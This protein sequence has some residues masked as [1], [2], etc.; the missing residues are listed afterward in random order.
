M[1]I[2]YIPSGY[3]R[4]YLYFDDAIINELV[5]LKHK[6]KI[7]NIT[8]NIESLP[9]IVLTFKPDLVLTM[10][11][12]NMP[13]ALLTSIKQMRIPSAIW[14]TE[15]PYYTDKTLKFIHNYDFIFT[16]ESSSVHLYEEAGHNKVYYLPLGTNPSIYTSLNFNQYKYDISLVGFPYPERIKIIQFL[17]DHTP[18]SILTVGSTWHLAL[19]KYKTTNNY[20]FIKTWVEPDKVATIYNQTKIVLNTHRPYKYKRNHNNKGIINRSINNR[21]FEIASCAA[22]QLTDT[23]PDLPKHFIPGKEIVTFTSLPDLLQKT[24]YYLKNEKERNEIAEK[25]RKKV[26]QNDTFT[27]RLNKMLSIINI[28][29]SK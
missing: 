24:H 28:H 25:A 26:L 21:T 27:H 6:V 20:H 5:N 9:S 13:S 29:K 16:I 7:F 22:F 23:K 19:A 1:K 12:F 11:G 15:D 17:L 8:E 18:Y 4:M 3:K 2:L 10:A 14:L